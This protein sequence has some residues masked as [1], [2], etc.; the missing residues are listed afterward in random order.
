MSEC[1]L[2]IFGWYNYGMVVHVY[3]FTSDPVMRRTTHL[4]VL[5]GYPVFYL[6][7]GDKSLLQCT[8]IAYLF[9]FFSSISYGIRSASIDTWY[10]AWEMIVSFISDIN[11]YI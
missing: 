11:S 8:V 6:N 7:L 5:D 4:Q 9:P 3:L 10:G 1:V 2:H